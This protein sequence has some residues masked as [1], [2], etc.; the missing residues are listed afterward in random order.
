[1]A[2]AN[3]NIVVTPIALSLSP[4]GNQTPHHFHHYLSPLGVTPSPFANSVASTNSWSSRLAVL[5]RSNILLRALAFLLSFASALSLAAP[6]PHAA[7]GP[8]AAFN[9]QDHPEFSYCLS[10]VIV[11]SIYSALQ[12][13]KSIWDIAFKGVILPEKISDYITFFLDQVVAYLLISSS[14]ISMLATVRIPPQRYRAAAIVS[15]I[16]SLAAFFA[17]A[18]SAIISGYKL[19]KRIIW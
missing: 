11:T 18:A 9:F 4:P 12:L 2:A 6:P 15:T 8:Q 13:F 17:I 5:R 3:T 7:E 16:A 10:A 1:M 14:S 19:C